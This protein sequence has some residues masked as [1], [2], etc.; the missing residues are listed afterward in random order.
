MED[1][2]DDDDDDEN[3]LPDD[4]SMTILGWIRKWND[5]TTQG[6]KQDDAERRELGFSIPLYPPLVDPVGAEMM[7]CFCVCRPVGS[8]LALFVFDMV[9]MA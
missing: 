6:G 3:L 5:G 7:L 2:D 4:R 8:P 1:G 9:E